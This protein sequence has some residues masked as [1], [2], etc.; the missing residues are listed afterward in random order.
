M[1]LHVVSTGQQS[2]IEL[3]DSAAQI[4]PWV[5]AIHIREK[6][7]S[8][9]EL[10]Q[11]VQHM[12]AKGVNPS[13]IRINSRPQLASHLNIGGVHLAEHITYAHP[14]HI[15]QSP[16]S[17]G[18][19]VHSIEQAVQ[20]QQEAMDYIF[21]GHIYATASKPNRTPRGLVQLKNIC[22]AVEIPV[23][24]IG[25][26]QPMNCAE[27]YHAGAAG[28]AV[29]SG[30]LGATNSQEICRAYYKSI[31]MIYLASTQYYQGGDFNHDSCVYTRS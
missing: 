30:I 22:H 15:S 16:W 24:A 25:G 27:L 18:R 23:I 21:Y 14:D 2:I 1:E 13:K 20:A 3:A 28:I 10:T 7:W 26:I 4:H 17:V 6:K 5:T 29:M 19:S 31:Q 9:L 8:D 12:I 11:A